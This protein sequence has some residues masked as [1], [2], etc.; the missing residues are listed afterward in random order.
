MTTGTTWTTTGTTRT[1]WATGTPSAPVL[2]KALTR[3]H[4]AILHHGN[5]GTSL[6][7]FQELMVAVREAAAVISAAE[8]SMS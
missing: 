5:S 6:A 3:L 2:L 4:D 8:R 1:I 7:A